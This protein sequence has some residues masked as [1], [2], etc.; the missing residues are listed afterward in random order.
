MTDSLS[1]RRKKAKLGLTIQPKKPTP[2]DKLTERMQ[3][4]QDEESNLET[5]GSRVLAGRKRQAARGQ[6]RIPKARPAKKGGVEL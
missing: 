6:A 5:Q 2:Y 4:G 1:S 3:Q